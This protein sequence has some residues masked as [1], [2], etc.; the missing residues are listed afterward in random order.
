MPRIPSVI[1]IVAMASVSLGSSGASR[2]PGRQD[3]GDLR[4]H[5]SAKLHRRRPASDREAGRQAWAGRCKGFGHPRRQRVGGNVVTDLL[6]SGNVE[7]AITG[8]IPFMVLWDKTRGPQ[9]VRAIASMSEC[10]VFL[11]SADPKISTIDDYSTVDRIAM[12]DVKSTTWALLLQ[13]AAGQEIRLG[14]A[15]E[16]RAAQR[17]HGER[18]G[19]LRDAVGQDRG[20][21]AHDHAA[22]LGSR[23]DD[24]P[25]Q[26]S[27]EFP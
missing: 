12:T 21:V 2:S 26:N 25:H 5:T 23:T 1:P 18:R 16:V 6:L 20:Q 27:V 11:F 15:A 19:Y 17:R 13:M 14:A 24:R 9:K 10:N 8:V 4:S 7:V 22:F 3:W